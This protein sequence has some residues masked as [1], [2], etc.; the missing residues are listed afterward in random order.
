MLGKKIPYTGLV[1]LSH[2][3]ERDK[4]ERIKDRLEEYGIRREDVIP[5]ADAMRVPV[6]ALEVWIFGEDVDA[7]IRVFRRAETK[8][9][10]PGGHVERSAR[11][12]PVFTIPR[13]SL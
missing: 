6:G 8:E 5:Y 10:K 7:E 11:S 9:G 3:Y 1:Y 4:I 13:K 12:D 2:A